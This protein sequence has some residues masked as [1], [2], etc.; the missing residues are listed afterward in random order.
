MEPLILILVVFVLVIVIG[1]KQA[2]A[3]LE[4]GMED[5]QTRIRETEARQRPMEKAE[6]APSLA[7]AK[8]AAVPGVPLGTES[9]APPQDEEER[10]TVSPELA[11]VSAETSLAPEPV[12][13]A[14][15]SVS[16]PPLEAPT[17]E[18][19]PEEPAVAARSAVP[20]PLPGERRT[21]AASAASPPPDAL[22]EPSRFETAAREI[23]A[24][25]WN[26]IVVGEEHRPAGVT[27]EYAVASTWLLRAGVIILL[28]GIGFFLRYS[29]AH[30]FLGPTGKVLL[31][32]LGGLGLLFG[33]L[34]IVRGRYALLGQGLAGAGFAT[35]YFSFFTAREEGLIGSVAAFAVMVLVTVAAGVVSLRYS[36][37][38]VAVLGLVGGYLT[39]MMIVGGETGA[40]VLFTYLLVLGAGVFFLASRRDWRFLHYLSFAGTWLLVL[41]EIVAGGFAPDQFWVWMLYFVAFFV[42]FSTV[43][44]IHQLLQ[45]EKATLLVL[46]FLF[47]NAGVF[48]G[49]AW[50]ITTRVLPKEAVAVVTVGL[51]LFYLGHIAFFLNRGIRDR[52]LLMSF[53]G[54]ASLFAAITLPL[55]LSGGWITVSWSAQAFVMLWIAARMR[56]EFLRQLAYVLYLV[57]LARF[58]VFDL[59]G[60]FGG[61]AWADEGQGYWLPFL[62]RL[63]VLGLP[64]ASFFAA[65]WLFLREGATGPEGGGEEGTL[66]VHRDND[67]RPWFSQSGLSRVC[68][69]IVLALAFIHFNFEAH[70]SAGVL[71][72]PLRLPALTLV[73]LLFAAI[74]LRE[75]LAGDGGLAKALFWILSV[76]LLLKVFSIHFLAYGLGSVVSGAGFQW[77]H[78]G[79]GPLLRLL[80]FGS[81]LGFFVV[82]WRIFGRRP[83]QGEAAQ[84]FGYTA[85]AGAFLYTSMEVWTGL[86]HYLRGFQF[87]GLSIYWALFALGLLLVGISQ[88]LRPL[89]RIGLILMAGTVFK[90]FFVDL[91][92]LDQ[93]YRI[94][95]FLVL[96][97]VVLV[98]SFLYLKYRHRFIIGEAEESRSD[99]G[100]DEPKGNAEVAGGSADT[101]PAKT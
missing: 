27:L 47:L 94:V 71:F 43:T 55:V 96:G 15:S 35:L 56:S 92:G 54:L 2:L 14:A 101:E 57:V 3:R 29:I 24:K 95:A 66:P 20:P 93:L 64:I 6:L 65:G 53:L 44:F 80:E 31:A 32:I 34:R 50:E 5:L 67:I 68:F 36:S 41:R 91:A 81:L 37:M 49:F 40:V 99:R 69:W 18:T 45:R 52:G 79:S 75:W 39:P 33:G 28:V 26:W 78:F 38:L 85:L 72:D 12:A 17:P 90:V 59:H 73:W 25:I 1:S 60:Q 77:G 7:R 58:A 11:V 74:L 62:E 70:Y 4:R 21:V 9:L 13:S 88:G 87:A 97:V 89:R 84:L 76:L 10:A 8:A 98:G 82:A 42:L 86:G 61:L 51:S 16:E 63:A 23:L 46:L 100:G 83:A 48:F 19:A 22:R 30:G